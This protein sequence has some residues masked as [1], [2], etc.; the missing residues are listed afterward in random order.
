MKALAVPG[1]FLLIIV[2]FGA[3]SLFL[4]EQAVPE[5]CDPAT[6]A[7]NDF[8]SGGN[9]LRCGRKVLNLMD[10]MVFCLVC[11]ISIDVSPAFGIEVK[12]EVGRYT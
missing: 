4:S 5:H 6:L 1:F 10:A 3:C 11:V 2:F 8:D 9:V 7:A 12:S